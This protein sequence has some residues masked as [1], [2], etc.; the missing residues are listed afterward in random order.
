MVN[1]RLRAAIYSAGLSIDEVAEALGKDRKT[2]ERWINGHL[3]YRRNQHAMANLLGADPGY[4]WPPGTAEQSANLGMAEVLAIWPVRSVV[5]TRVWVEVFEAAARRID[6]LVYAGFWLSEDP[7]IRKTLLRKA[8]AGV[9]V[10]FLLGDPDSAAVALRGREEGIGEAI[11]AKIRN[12]VHNY[13]ALIEAPNTEFRIH[14]TTLY[15]SIYR[16]DDEMLVNNHIYGLPGHM[17]PL[18]RLRRVPGAELFAAHLEGF[19]RVWETAA[20]LEN[21]QVVA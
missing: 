9:R 6:V 3:P 2:V 14:D 5:P 4:L 21:R 7:A 12:T 11:S 20:R 17:T 15:N 19:D 16:A 8:R 13:R 18:I 1:E 10:R